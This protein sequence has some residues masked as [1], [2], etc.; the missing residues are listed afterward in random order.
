MKIE[1]RRGKYEQADKKE[2][3]KRRRGGAGV[4]QNEGGHS[5]SGRGSSTAIFL[6]STE[7]AKGFS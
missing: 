5:P 2:L 7:V 4:W 6:L 3:E 1:G